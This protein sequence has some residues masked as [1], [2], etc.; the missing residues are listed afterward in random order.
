MQAQ[1]RQSS[2]NKINVSGWIS[3]TCQQDSFVKEY[4]QHIYLSAGRELKE[5]W[6]QMESAVWAKKESRPIKK[7][8]VLISLL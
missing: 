5:V 3:L 1:E 4:Q 8:V 6:K 7:E 2:K